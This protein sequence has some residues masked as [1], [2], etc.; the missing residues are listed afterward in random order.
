MCKKY[1]HIFCERKLKS[2]KCFKEKFVAIPNFH[3][4]PLMFKNLNVDSYKECTE[5]ISQTL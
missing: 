5:F 3:K 1:Y 2:S 4:K